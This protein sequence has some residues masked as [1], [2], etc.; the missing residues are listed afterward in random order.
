ME[1]QDTDSHF[2]P[3]CGLAVVAPC[4]FP[5]DPLLS[6]FPLALP[7]GLSLGYF[8]RE[9][10]MGELTL[11]I[12]PATLLPWHSHG[13][14]SCMWGMLVVRLDQGTDGKFMPLGNFLPV[15]NL[16]QTCQVQTK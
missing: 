14:L 1:A 12:Q 15:E 4:F 8:C 10:D 2:L 9:V 3:L 5:L 7:A 6:P 16:S 11:P 13:C